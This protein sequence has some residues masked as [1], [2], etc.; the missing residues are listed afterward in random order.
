MLILAEALESI[1]VSVFI[2]KLKQRD[3]PLRKIVSILEFST[4]AKLMLMLIGT[5]ELPTEM[6][7][8]YD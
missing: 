3:N 5:I 6:L 7:G 4:S 8:E 2:P 1:G